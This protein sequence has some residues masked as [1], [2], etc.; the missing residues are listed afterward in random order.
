MLALMLMHLRR[1]PDG[2]A[3]VF[4]PN[5]VPDVNNKT[6]RPVKMHP[7]VLSLGWGAALFSLWYCCWGPYYAIPSTAHPHDCPWGGSYVT[8]ASKFVLPTPRSIYPSVCVHLS[9]THLFSADGETVSR[10]FSNHSE[11]DLFVRYR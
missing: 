8:P 7:V 3:T 2:S 1:E 5:G 9:H 4:L 6:A 11:V 10:Q